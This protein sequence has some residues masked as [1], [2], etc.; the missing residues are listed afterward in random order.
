MRISVE[1]GIDLAECAESL[2]SVQERDVDEYYHCRPLRIWNNDRFDD[3]SAVMLDAKG[4]FK[5]IS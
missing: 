5:V 4:H 1:Q 2:I 3:E